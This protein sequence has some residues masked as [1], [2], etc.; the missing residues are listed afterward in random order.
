[1][2]CCNVDG[3]GR[4]RIIEHI[5]AESD[6]MDVLY[7]RLLSEGIGRL[8]TGEQVSKSADLETMAAVFET[9]RWFP[10]EHWVENASVDE[11]QLVSL[12]ASGPDVDPSSDSGQI[13]VSDC[14]LGSGSFTPKTERDRFKARLRI[15]FL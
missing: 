3:R 13:V 14:S 15:F 1:M 9:D 11:I 7:I 6:V 8:N 2:A 5:T 10:L 12:L 4:Y